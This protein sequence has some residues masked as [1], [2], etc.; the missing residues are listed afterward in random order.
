MTPASVPKRNPTALRP[1][2]SQ[3]PIALAAIGL[4]AG[5]WF[6]LHR[7]EAQARDTIRK[8][9]L[10][11]VED[12]LYFGYSLHG[13]YPPYDEPMWCGHLNDTTPPSTARQEIEAALRQQNE[14]YA[15]PAKPF[16]TDPL[17]EDRSPRVAPPWAGRSEAGRSPD[18]F[19][20][21]RSPAVF[22]LYSLLETDPNHNRSTHGC[23]ATS[24]EFFDYGLNSR[25]RAGA[26]AS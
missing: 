13:T 6:L 5:G 4:L 23:P 11:D 21:K 26:R 7:S 17:P 2:F 9:H 10:Q 25:L 8:H 24:P 20:W 18:Y 3:L 15:N 12:A 14:K 1:C 16:P 19:Y 22:E